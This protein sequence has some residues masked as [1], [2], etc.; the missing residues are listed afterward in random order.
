MVREWFALAGVL[1]L[2]TACSGPTTGTATGE[3]ATTTARSAGPATAAYTPDRCPTPNVAGIPQLDLGP[4]FSCGYLTVP[5]NRARPDGPTIRVGVARIKAASP[6]PRP[7]PIVWLTGGPGGTAI[8]TAN[9]TVAKGVNADRDVIFVDQRGT[10]H[11]QPSLVC[12]EIDAFQRQALGLRTADPATA[13]Q[14]DAATR[15]CHDRI[16]G[17]GVDLAA[18]DTTQNAA[19]IADLRVALGVEQWNVRGVSYGTDLA[20]QLLR[21]HPQGIRSVVLDSVVPPYVNLIAGLWP[22][23]AAGYRALFDACAAQPACAAAYPDLRA[24]F[25]SLVR[26]LDERPLTAEVADPAGGPAIAV[27]IDGYKLANLVNVLALNPGSLTGAP[28]MVHALALGDPGPAARALLE[29]VSPPG[30]NGFGL[31]FGVVCREHAA[32]TDPQA[33][34]AEARHALPDLPDRVLASTPQVPRIFQDCG[35]WNAGRADPA[36]LQPTRSDIA[37]LLLNGAL[38]GITPPAW[39]E[40]AGTGLTNSKVLVLPGA[41]HDVIQWN[42]CAVPVMLA[43]LDNPTGGYDTECVEQLSTPPFATS[44]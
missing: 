22:N 14:S 41:G 30:L 34:Q 32:F 24:E 7:D 2:V 5:E 38:D 44:G 43:F 8:A 29:T 3:G 13:E 16:A 21:D 1:A 6:E 37:V 35:I 10:L 12:P 26:R 17:Q 27:L 25:T 19:D 28:A 40:S 42:D 15:A 33:T 23:A 31:Q 39:A 11:A 9:L 18:F 4:G 36:T 20:L